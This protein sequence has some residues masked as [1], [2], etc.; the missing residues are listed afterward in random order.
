MKC[1]FKQRTKHYVLYILHLMK[2]DY[3]SKHHK[4]SNGMTD[5]IP[6]YK[7][8]LYIFI[9]LKVSPCYSQ[10]PIISR[11]NRQSKID[12]QWDPSHFHW[13][14][15]IDESFKWECHQSEHP[16]W[17]NELTSIEHCHINHRCSCIKMSF[18]KQPNH[19]NSMESTWRCFIFLSFCYFL[20]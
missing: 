9:S 6:W 19:I 8:F 14:M 12:N 7:L 18:F 10:S 11:D 17:I 3:S 4:G 13:A 20:S 2:F 1:Y 16:K 5:N 15:R